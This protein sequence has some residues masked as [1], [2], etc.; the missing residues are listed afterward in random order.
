MHSESQSLRYLQ[1]L[2]S[3]EIAGQLATIGVA[4]FWLGLALPLAPMLSV[5]GALLVLLLLTWVRLRWGGPVR[6]AELFAQ[7]L[8]DVAALALLIYFTGGATNPFVSLFLLPLSVAA[9]LLSAPQAWAMAFV[10]VACYT[11]LLEYYVPLPGMEQEAPLTTLVSGGRHALHMHGGGQFGLH[12]LGMWL[13]F[14]ISAALITFFVQRFAQTLRAREREL[15]RA[16]EEA[17]RN[18]RIVAL[19]TLAAGTAHELGTPLATVAVVA[20]ELEEEFAGDP[21]LA[22]QLA[23]IRTQVG[24]CKAVL[25]RLVESVEQL[26]QQVAQEVSL[27]AFL[28]QVAE[29]WRLLWPAMALTLSSAVGPEVRIRTD[30]T[31]EQAL[32]NL[33]NNAARVSAAGVELAAVVEGEEAVL[34]ILDR[35]PG[36]A[37]ETIEAAGKRFLMPPSGEGLGIGLYLAN[38]TIERFKGRVAMHNRLGG[39]AVT[40][41]RLPLVRGEGHG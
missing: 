29:R 39:G 25:Q 9:A 15:S 38:A 33:L 12:V 20:A 1:V 13:N 31:L 17:L 21:D 41:V 2:R 6:E 30:D 23:L 5:V 27:P 40:E 8:V 28:K 18:E 35:G 34:R 36:L 14:V 10:T 16:R 11:L 22:P 4:V 24:Q 19:G 32:L 3:I 7:L 37:R 26:P